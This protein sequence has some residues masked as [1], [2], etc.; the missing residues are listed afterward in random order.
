MKIVSATPIW[1]DA[2]GHQHSKPSVPVFWEVLEEKGYNTAE[3]RDADS[4]NGVVLNL[5]DRKIIQ[6]SGYTRER[7]L[8]CD[9]Y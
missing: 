7:G 6:A 8:F 1:Y 5:D 3:I 2:H 4:I 9:M